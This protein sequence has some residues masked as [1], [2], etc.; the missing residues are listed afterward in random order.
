VQRRRSQLFGPS[1]ILAAGLVLL[2]C[3]EPPKP[4]PATSASAAEA[5]PVDAKLDSALKAVE[6]Q[7]EAQSAPSASA[8]QPPP[9]GIFAPGEAD[10][11]HP[12]TLAPKVELLDA[13]AEPRL[14][15]GASARPD[16]EKTK[17]LVSLS[18]GGQQ[19]LPP[20]EL[21]LETAKVGDDDKKKP[22][23]KGDEAP[24]PPGDPR[25]V[26]KLVDLAIAGD[27]AVP[28][29][30]ADTLA[31]MKGSTLT[32]TLTPTGP[33]AF[34]RKLA[35]DADPALEI[36]LR[37]VEDSITAVYVPTPSQPVGEGGY[38]MVTDR[39]PALGVDVVR[40]RVFRV[41]KVEGD[42]ALLGVDIRQYAADDRVDLPLGPQ[43]AGASLDTYGCAAKGAVDLAPKTI[44]PGAAQIALR[45]Q[46]GVLPP[47]AK[48]QP[49]QQRPRAQMMIELVGQLGAEPKSAALVM[50]G[51]E[52]GG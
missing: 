43:L 13:G 21:S 20:L 4:S 25:Y 45:V 19:A 23:A 29:Q 35:K 1:S 15:L 39:R 3:E 18:T 16:K 2:G 11:A 33:M 31:K 9:N 12:S 14:A 6:K 28:K 40:Y 48:A 24:A 7:G 49:A 52:G 27:A 38:W 50:A 10:R 41:V 51:Q 37:A 8:N 26:T 32:F 34:E 47:G 42:V 36:A 46:A 30:M 44:F 5:P 17:L 22:D